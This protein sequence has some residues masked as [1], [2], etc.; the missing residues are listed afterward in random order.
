MG[1]IEIV[2][3]VAAT[4]TTSAFV[5]QVYKAFK[6]KSTKDVSLT[7]YTVF[8][9]G[10]IL[11]L[12]YGINIQSLSVILANGITSLLAIL[13]LMLKIKYK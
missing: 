2:G 6:N 12:I 8:L 5:P 13:M 9:A 10:T 11:W 3:L 1:N 7:M 4:L